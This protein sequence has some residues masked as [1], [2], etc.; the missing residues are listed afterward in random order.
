MRSARRRPK[1][2]SKTRTKTKRSIG[3]VVGGEGAPPS[4]DEA[5]NQMVHSVDDRRRRSRSPRPA[6]PN[7]P[8]EVRESLEKATDVR[9]RSWREQAA[10][11][12]RPDTRRK[13][14]RG[15]LDGAQK[16]LARSTSGHRRERLRR[17]RRDDEQRERRE[18]GRVDRQRRR[19][20]VLL[21]VVLC[22]RERAGTSFASR[23]IERGDRVGGHGDGEERGGHRGA[24]WIADARR[25]RGGDQSGFV[26][27]DDERAR[28]S[29]H[30]STARI[31]EASECGDRVERAEGRGPTRG[32]E[33]RDEGCDESEQ[34]EEGRREAGTSRRRRTL[35]FQRPFRCSRCWVRLLPNAH[36]PKRMRPSGLLQL[37]RSLPRSRL[38]LTIFQGQPGAAEKKTS[39]R[40]LRP[41]TF[42]RSS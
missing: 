4:R 22:G 9:D 30:R 33:H 2:R 40:R 29:G 5:Q 1:T 23:V 6:D 31:T 18:D 27:D 39:T 15:M 19:G 3:R 36:E 21:P 12:I 8:C 17:G 16:R 34:R 10:R 11:K 38:V 41:S 14:A 7:G 25:Q 42:R 24:A 13:S 35:C 32:E 20:I 37:C 28:R 26:F